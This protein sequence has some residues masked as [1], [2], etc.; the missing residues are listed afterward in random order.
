MA[1]LVLSITRFSGLSARYRVQKNALPQL[2]VSGHIKAVF[3]RYAPRF[4]AATW[5]HAFSRN[6]KAGKTAVENGF[7][8]GWPQLVGWPR[9]VGY[10][11]LVSGVQTGAYSASWFAPRDGDYSTDDCANG[12]LGLH[13]R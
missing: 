12:K 10:G 5:L 1:D 3:R 9:L 6:G 7:A 4:W 13:E 11:R 2:A 8:V